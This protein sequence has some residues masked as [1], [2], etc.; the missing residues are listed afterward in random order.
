MSNLSRQFRS[1]CSWTAD[2]QVGILHREFSLYDCYSRSNVSSV[3]FL[4]HRF[5]LQSMTSDQLQGFSRLFLQCQESELLSRIIWKTPRKRVHVIFTIDS[6]G[7]TKPLVQIS[8]KTLVTS[9][10][11]LFGEISI[12]NSFRTS[13]RMIFAKEVFDVQKQKWVFTDCT[14]E[15]LDRVVKDTDIKI[16]Q[17]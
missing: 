3:Y 9:Y 4:T 12:Y 16:E 7:T 5:E 2:S 15:M 6:R 10:S 1:F 14:R 11:A 17:P 8:L 13:H